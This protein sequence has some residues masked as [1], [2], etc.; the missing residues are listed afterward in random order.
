M[1]FP[2]IMPVIEFVAC[3]TSNSDTM[4]VS[5]A[6]VLVPMM[7]VP[8]MEGFRAMIPEEDTVRLPFVFVIYPLPSSWNIVFVIV[9]VGPPRTILV[10]D[11]K[12]PR[13][14]RDEVLSMRNQ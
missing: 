2:T 4:F 5:V 1:E 10:E 7:T 12:A 9:D 14:I 3:Q 6:G 13:Y 8:F 11:P